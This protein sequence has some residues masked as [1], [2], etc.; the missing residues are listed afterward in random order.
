MSITDYKTKG[1]NA[2]R[3]GLLAAVAPA[4]GVLHRNWAV[5]W[6][7]VREAIDA[8]LEKGYAIMPA[9]G[10]DGIPTLRPLGTSEVGRWIN[11]L[12]GRADLDM[13]G[14]RITSHS[15]K[16]T[17]LSFL[18]KFG[19]EIGDRE[20]LGAHVSHLKSVIRYS[21]D[22][23]GGPLRV[24]DGMLQMIREQHFFPDTTRSGYF[25]PGWQPDETAEVVLLSDDE[26]VKQE[27]SEDEQPESDVL[28]TDSSSDEEAAA[29]AHCGRKVVLPKAPEGFRLFQH[30]KSRMLHLMSNDHQKVFQCGRTA[31][32]KHEVPQTSQL[33]W[34][35]PCCGRCWRASGQALGSRLV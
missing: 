27:P 28:E 33:R 17:M 30:T 3:G 13:T 8:P 9:P 4:I 24:L 20:I 12:L 11:M 2:W 14:R 19:A 26:E 16:A 18:A 29:E 10:P 15:A 21:R 22:A 7:E 25:A 34:D 1:A 35:T 5:D 32:E 31:G 23:L 6:L